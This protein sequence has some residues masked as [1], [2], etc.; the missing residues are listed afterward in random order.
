MGRSKNND[1]NAGSVTFKFVYTAE[2]RYVKVV[3]TLK[4]IKLWQNYLY[5][6]VKQCLQLSL[7]TIISSYK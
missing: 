1:T 3:G 5:Q 7:I 6:L 4:N 2:L